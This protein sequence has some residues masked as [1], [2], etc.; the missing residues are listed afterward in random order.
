MPHDRS[1][2]CRGMGTLELV[3][4]NSEG[5]NRMAEADWKSVTLGEETDCCS[6][7]P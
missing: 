6:D 3:S 7:V 4:E 1:R 5:F 2:D